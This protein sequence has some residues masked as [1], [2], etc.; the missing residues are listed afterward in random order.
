MKNKIYLLL[1][2]VTF[3]SCSKESTESSNPENPE[4]FKLLKRVT[5]TDFYWGEQNLDFSYS[6][7]LLVKENGGGE[8]V[9]YEYNSDGK[10]SLRQECSDQNLSDINLDSY[11]C[12]EF[13][14]ATT[15]IYENG[16]LKTFGPD[17]MF[18]KF[19]YDGNGN[20]ISEVDTG[21]PTTESSYYTY[22]NQGNITTMD[23]IDQDG[24][25]Y[26]VTYEYDG[27]INPF[28]VLWKKYGYFVD[29]EFQ[30]YDLVS[31]VFKQNATK[32]FTNNI[33]DMEANYTY[34]SDGYPIS[35]GF[36]EYLS[37]GSTRQGTVTFT[38]N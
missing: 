30:P 8:L 6:D 18:I 16:K 2:A 25:V 22:N 13:Y 33:L 24:E 4:N 32:V 35:C 38:Y 9:Y 17:E 1:I 12:S 28:Y 36:T 27:K 29:Q 3:L 14:P 31:S 34:D 26:R 11:N 10:I 5:Y 20:L 19:N 23:L 21:G 15:Y 7:G 37:N